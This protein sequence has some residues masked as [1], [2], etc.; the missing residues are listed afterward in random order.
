MPPKNYFDCNDDNDGFNHDSLSKWL[1]YFEDMLKPK[2]IPEPELMNLTVILYND[3]FSE[4]DTE[5][6][7]S[8]MFTLNL[9]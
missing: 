8:L 5:F 2:N 6:I 4:Q 3:K 7:P 9:N 1:K